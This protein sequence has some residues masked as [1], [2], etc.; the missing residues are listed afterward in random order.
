MDTGRGE[1]MNDTRILRP[2]DFGSTEWA[3][4]EFIYEP[5]EGDRSALRCVDIVPVPADRL[6]AVAAQYQDD[7]QARR[8]LA[9]QYKDAL[10]AYDVPR[11]KLFAWLL[12]KTKG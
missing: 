12:E 8:W 5:L 6:Q 11:L 2:P 1:E 9:Q 4:R 3:W 7:D 10:T